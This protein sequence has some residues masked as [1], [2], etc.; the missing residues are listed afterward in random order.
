[1][2]RLKATLFGKFNIER[3]G[4]RV[5]GLEARKVQ[6]LLSY[7]LVYR[8]HPHSR[9]FLSDTLW[10]N[11]TSTDAQKC[12]RQT[13]WRLQSAL[14][15]KDNSP[16]TDI[17]VH[18]TW[19]QFNLSANFWLDIDEFE[20]VFDLEKG[21]TARELSLY[22]YDAM[23]NAANIYKGDLLEGWY[24]EWC[25]FE[26]ERFQIM[27][28]MLLDKLVQYC[29]LHELYEAGLAY[30]TQI[31]RR[32]HA[33]ERT[34]RQLMRLYYMTGNRT[35]ALRQYERCVLALHDELGVEPT[36]QTK[37]LHEQIRLDTFKPSP[38][39]HEKAVSKVK[40]KATPTLQDVLIHLAEVSETL[41]KIEQKIQE[42][43]IE[44]DDTLEQK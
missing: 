43:F 13:L 42:E 28:L 21:K 11:R 23:E 9:E 2:L 24:Q 30:G 37:V 4:Q 20:K 1:M 14:R 12:M 36:E 40:I 33:Y 44:F 35:Q 32:D 16:S 26:R 25:I 3:E 7:L 31:L 27:H 34:H 41:I 38:F 29:E 22:D 19:I 8:N 6:E 15:I 39:I 17:L 5:E 10:N 18:N